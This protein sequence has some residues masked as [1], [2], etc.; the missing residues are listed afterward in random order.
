MHSLKE[1][2]MA[3]DDPPT[4]V[5]DELDWIYSHIHREE[6]Q[7]GRIQA[8]IVRGGQEVAEMD[9]EIDIIESLMKDVGRG[10]KDG[11]FPVGR[12]E[13]LHEQL[14]SLQNLKQ[15]K[16]VAITN[17][18]K[19]LAQVDNKLKMLESITNKVTSFSDSD[20]P[21]PKMV[22]QAGDAPPPP[23]RPYRPSPLFAGG[24][25]ENG[26]QSLE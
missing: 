12:L 3:H 24:G 19:A 6:E 15:R 7:K 16:V 18:G 23:Y 26:G 1:Q 4:S 2:A 22:E 9:K 14:N 20:S 11:P 8:A 13:Y 5:N 25:E 10:M 17:S 21:T